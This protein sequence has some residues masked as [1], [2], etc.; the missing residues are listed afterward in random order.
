M[1][2][3]L[4]STEGRKQY[5]SEKLD[6]LLEGINDS[7]GTLL[8]EELLAR[9]ELTV[10]DFNDEMKILC[11]QLVQK[12]EERQQLMEMLK[13]TDGIPAPASDTQQP[14][15]D[16]SETVDPGHMEIEELDEDVPEWEKK[17]AKLEK[18]VT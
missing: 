6:D 7:Y 15:P 1:S 10:R 17:L 8:M 3:D 16:T 14:T 9:L 2:I 5:L 11:D 4:D 18:K 13:T 12:E